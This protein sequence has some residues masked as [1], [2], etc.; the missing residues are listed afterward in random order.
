MDNAQETESTTLHARVA[1][2]LYTRIAAEG[3]ER[4]RSVSWV[5]GDILRRY[6]QR[7]D[8]EKE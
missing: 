8:R 1:R 2:T 4:D 3:E 5:V 6:F 7:K